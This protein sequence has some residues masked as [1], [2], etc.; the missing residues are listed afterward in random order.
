MQTNF[1]IKNNLENH[2][3]DLINPLPKRSADIVRRRFGLS[4]KNPQTL[5]HIGSLYNITRERVRQI[6][7]DAFKRLKKAKNLKILKDFLADLNLLFE[8][9]GKVISEE[10]LFNQF[11]TTSQNSVNFL[12]FLARGFYYYPDQKDLKSLWT[13]D[14]SRIDLIRKLLNKIINIS[15]N[16]KQVFTHDEIFA[17]IKDSSIIKNFK[18]PDQAILSYLETSKHIDQNVFGEFGLSHWPEIMP[19]GVKDK[20][21]LVLKKEN[22]PLHFAKIAEK[23]NTHFQDRKALSQTVHNE[24]IKDK[25]FVLVG[26]GLYALEEHGYMPGTVADVMAAILKKANQPLSLPQIQKELFK[27]RFISPSTVLFNLKAHDCFEKLE[28]GKYILKNTNK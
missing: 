1:T 28:D 21:Y 13:T 26:R 17:T 15:Q 10:R 6:E 19:R 7:L 4:V 9:Q 3:H 24:I 25:R 8:E 27:E 22:K 5:A 16:K 18:I 2:V 11:I 20:A 12:L 14:T 23:I